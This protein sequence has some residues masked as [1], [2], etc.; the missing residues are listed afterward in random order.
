MKET[1]VLLLGLIFLSH[2]CLAEPSR[3]L[4]A[5]SI[6]DVK[7]TEGQ[8]EETSEGS[9]A[10][11]VMKISKGL[12]FKLSPLAIQTLNLRFAPIHE[13]SEI[14]TLSRSALVY[15]EDDVGVYR[16]R[17]GWFKLIKVHVLREAA[18]TVEIQTKDMKT[19]DDVVV[20]GAALV[21]VADI[22]ATGPGSH[23]Q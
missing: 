14:H 18:N 10:S 12:G 9:E 3:K 20:V 15:Y 7:T 5:N 21:H 22:E 11:A 19:G 8:V 16:R 2:S 6:E 13:D 1:I 17:S 23:V 4:A